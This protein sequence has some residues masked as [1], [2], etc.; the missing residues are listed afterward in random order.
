MKIIKNIAT[1][2]IGAMVFMSAC[3]PIEERDT[4]KNSYRAD[5]I[6][7]EV[8]QSSDG[9][10]NGLTLK[11]NTPG[12]YGYWDYKLGKKFSDE[13]SFVSPFMGNVTFTYHATTPIISG[14]DPSAREY[15]TKSIDVNV[16]VADN[17]VHEAY[18]NL[19]GETLGSKSWVFDKES[20]EPWWYMSD[21]GNYQAVWWNAGAE[22]GSHPPDVDGKMIFDLNGNANFTHYTNADDD[23]GT[24]GAFSFNANYTKLYI[25]GDEKILGN[26]PALG[27]P[28]GEYDIIVLEADKMIL[29]IPSNANCGTCAH[30]WVFVPES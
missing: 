7:L 24:L 22:P 10:G 16:Q 20:G 28:S 14:G 23:T 9:T 21:P 2:F 1:L 12:V 4:L 30:V 26:T 11:M 18:Y 3:D 27:S 8:I 17:E 13:A 6:E 15:I 25:S 5:D 19:V 29:Q